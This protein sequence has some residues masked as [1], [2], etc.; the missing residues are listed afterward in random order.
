MRKVQWNIIDNFREKTYSHK[1]RLGEVLAHQAGKEAMK[2]LRQQGDDLEDLERWF[3]EE[4][5]LKVMEKIRI[6][7][8][9]TENM[10]KE[11]LRKMVQMWDSGPKVEKVFN[12]ETGRWE[13]YVMML[14]TKPDQQMTKETEVKMKEEDEEGKG[15]EPSEYKKERLKQEELLLK[16]MEEK[17]REEELLKKKWKKKER[18]EEWRV[19]EKK[20]KRNRMKRMMKSEKALK[21][22]QQKTKRKPKRK[23]KK[24]TKKEHDPK[25]HHAQPSPAETARII[26]ILES[27]YK[28][29]TA[30]EKK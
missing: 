16:K 17:V 26:K 1:L 11:D 24:S 18:V 14:G 23:S 21:D 15:E 10:Q 8:V 7:G 13:Y 27:S 3:I 5:E 22:V 25:A 19:R 6:K 4:K 20:I 12:V 29:K 28:F 9:D 30:K 2:K